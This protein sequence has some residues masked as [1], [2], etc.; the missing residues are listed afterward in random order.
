MSV[1]MHEPAVR[2]LGLLEG[3]ETTDSKS[4]GVG[5]F[6]KVKRGVLAWFELGG[7]RT[8][9]VRAEFAL[10]A[11]G[12]LADPY[13]LGNIGGVLLKP[14]VLVT[15]YGGGRIAFV[16]REGAAPVVEGE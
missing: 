12:A 15:D 1:A 3:R 7:V 10:E 13:S 9:A 6:V 5:G 11:K 4:G 8:E 16:P 14:F 2:E